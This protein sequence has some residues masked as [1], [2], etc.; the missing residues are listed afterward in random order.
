M[1]GQRDHKDP[2]ICDE[3]AKY[4]IIELKEQTVVLHKIVFFI[5]NKL[6]VLVK[7]MMFQET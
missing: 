3:F 2:S 7:Q 1:Q 4:Q 6:Y 5:Y